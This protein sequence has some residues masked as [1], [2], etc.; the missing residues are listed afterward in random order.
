MRSQRS[1]FGD[2]IFYAIYI[3]LKK[4]VIVYEIISSYV[5]KGTL[6]EE[7]VQVLSLKPYLSTQLIL[8]TKLCTRFLK[9]FVLNI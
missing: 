2:E 3:F 9:C 7:I 5:Q 4:R 8:R 1:S 6:Y